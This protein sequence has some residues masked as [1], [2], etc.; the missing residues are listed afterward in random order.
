VH[1][2]HRTDDHQFLARRA[3]QQRA[4]PVNYRRKSPV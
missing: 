4:Q 2:S 1:P 3:S